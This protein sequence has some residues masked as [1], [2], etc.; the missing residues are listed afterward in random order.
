VSKG[1]A[2]GFGLA[3]ARFSG[4]VHGGSGRINGGGE[5]I[6]RWEGILRG[7]WF[8]LAGVWVKRW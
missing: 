5:G 7:E 1:G 8:R 4:G 3:G 6:L 2:W